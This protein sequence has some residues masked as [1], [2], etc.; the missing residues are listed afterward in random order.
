MCDEPL[1]KHVQQLFIFRADVAGQDTALG[2][3][4]NRADRLAQNLP[5]DPGSSC[6]CGVRVGLDPEFEAQSVVAFKTTLI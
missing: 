1:R 2:H 4:P 3:F 5:L 6:A